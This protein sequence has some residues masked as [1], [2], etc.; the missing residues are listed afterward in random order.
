MDGRGGH[1]NFFWLFPKGVFGICPIHHFIERHIRLDGLRLKC[2]IDA[3]TVVFT[4]LTVLKVLK[5]SLRPGLI[6]QLTLIL[7]YSTGKFRTPLKKVMSFSVLRQSSSFSAST[8]SDCWIWLST[9]KNTA[10]LGDS[11][12]ASANAIITSFADRLSASIC[13]S[14]S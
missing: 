1:P 11:S 6:C 12:R 14:T 2:L 4:R 10:F 8:W 7:M 5:S 9:E 3:G 13:L